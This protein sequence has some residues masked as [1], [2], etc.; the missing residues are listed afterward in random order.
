MSLYKSFDQQFFA[1]LVAKNGVDIKPS[2]V[3]ITQIKSIV[4]TT[5]GET[6]GCNTQLRLLAT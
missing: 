5:I 6:T 1:E 4:G 2:D 3:V